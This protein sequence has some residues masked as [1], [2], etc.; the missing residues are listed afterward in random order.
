MLKSND[1]VFSNFKINEKSLSF[2][3]NDEE[4]FELLFF[5]KKRQFSKSFY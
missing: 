1:L 4:K 5:F 3:I 2:K